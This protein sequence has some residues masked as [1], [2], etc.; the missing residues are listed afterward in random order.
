MHYRGTKS[1]AHLLH[2]RAEQ[3][4]IGAIWKAL[5]GALPVILVCA[6]WAPANAHDGVDHGI[7]SGPT[8]GMPAW[9]SGNSSGPSDA[10]LEGLFVTL[11]TN[12]G[13]S[14][15]TGCVPITRPSSS[16]LSSHRT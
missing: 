10:V 15:S 3:A 16:K 11:W 2:L 6:P 13:N 9:R 5:A 8:D 1:R 14:L 7:E 12:D 4:A